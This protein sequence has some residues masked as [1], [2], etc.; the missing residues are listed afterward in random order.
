MNFVH[1][2]IAIKL[3]MTL[4]CIKEVHKILKIIVFQYFKKDWNFAFHIHPLETKRERETHFYPCFNV[5]TIS[6]NRVT[7]R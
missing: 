4:G 6:M 3:Y 5:K 7:K 1:S 2:V